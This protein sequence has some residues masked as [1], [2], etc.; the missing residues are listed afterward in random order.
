MRPNSLHPRDSRCTS[1]GGILEDEELA[2]VFHFANPW[3]EEKPMLPDW[4][5]RRAPVGPLAVAPGC[6]AFD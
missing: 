2:A 3:R 4:P 5:R 1:S 6:Q